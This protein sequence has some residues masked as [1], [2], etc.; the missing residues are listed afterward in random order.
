VVNWQIFEVIFVPS[1]ETAVICAVPVDTP[2]TMPD[3]LT[4]ATAGLLE[5]QVSAGFEASPGRTIAVSAVVVPALTNA[6][7]GKTICVT[8]IGGSVTETAAAFD[9]IPE[10]SVAAAVICV[11][12]K[13]TPVTTPAELTVATAVLLE[14]HASAGLLAFAGNTVAESVVSDPMVV[15]DVAGRA[16]LVTN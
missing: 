9:T 14:F 6:I 1:V 13:A 16:M 5:C 15:E 7:V 8:G 11:V 12:P 2:E 3:E 4:V 10:P